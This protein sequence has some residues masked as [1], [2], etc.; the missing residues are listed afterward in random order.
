M[1]IFPAR[2]HVTMDKKQYYAHAKKTRFSRN[3]MP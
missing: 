1:H 3:E 2:Y